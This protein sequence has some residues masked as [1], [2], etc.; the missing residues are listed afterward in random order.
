L[1]YF[2]AVH[3][4]FKSLAFQVLGICKKSLDSAAEES[5]RVA[6]QSFRA[7]MRM[8]Q[9][10]VKTTCRAFAR[11]AD[12]I[13][14]RLIMMRQM[15]AA[16]RFAATVSSQVPVPILVVLAS[17]ALSGLPKNLDSPCI[18]LARRTGARSPLVSTKKVGEA[19]ALDRPP[20][21]FAQ[22]VEEIAAA[23]SFADAPSAALCLAILG[24]MP[25]SLAAK[26]ALQIANTHGSKLAYGIVL[27]AQSHSR[28]CILL[29]RFV[30]LL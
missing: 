12:L 13:I 6:L 9:E 19:K 10:D 16:E 2:G 8:P 11:R 17:Q 3:R 4:R 15:N 22:R 26:H 23:F 27:F 18:S 30:I 24:I 1:F 28:A 7:W 20:A 29:S 21:D 25:L 5:W 14:V